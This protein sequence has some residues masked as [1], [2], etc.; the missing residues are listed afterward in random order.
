MYMLSKANNSRLLAVLYADA[1]SYKRYSKEV[2]SVNLDAYSFAPN[3]VRGHLDHL[4]NRVEAHIKDTKQQEQV[5]RKQLESMDYTEFLNDKNKLKSG[6]SISQQLTI[7]YMCKCLQDINE[8]NLLKEYASI[9]SN[10]SM[11]AHTSTV[12]LAKLIRKDNN[13]GTRT[14]TVS[15][16]E[17]E[18]ASIRN[19]A[20]A[21]HYM[22]GLMLRCLREKGLS[23]TE[24]DD[25]LNTLEQ[26]KSKYDEFL[27]I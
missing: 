3:E 10:L 20:T 27:P 11:Y 5:C 9:Y 18:E 19:L 24:L 17:N 12:Y 13:G 4:N 26:S 22:A 16:K 8:R 21:H 2:K 15:E 25:R 1:V 6:D 14:G 7:R 23:Q